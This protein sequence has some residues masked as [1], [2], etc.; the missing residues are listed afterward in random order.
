MGSG[1]GREMNRHRYVQ[2]NMDD[3]DH[4]DRWHASVYI[5]PYAINYETV[6]IA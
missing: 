6:S 2:T 3:I 4:Y 1:I 5:A